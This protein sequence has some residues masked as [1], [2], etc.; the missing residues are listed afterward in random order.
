MKTQNTITRLSRLMITGIAAVAMAGC[1]TSNLPEGEILYTGIKSI[2]YKDTLSVE[3][4]DVMT[5]RRNKVGYDYFGYL[6]D[7]KTEVEAALACA[8]NGAILGSSYM[9]TPLQLRLW[10]YNALA[11]STSKVGRWLRDN[12]G[13]EPVLVSAVN[14]E[15]RSLVAENVLRSYGFFDAQVDYAVIRKD[16]AKTGKIDYRVKTRRLSVVD[17]LKYV[18]FTPAVDSLIQGSASVSL[19]HSGYPFS[20]A[21]LDAERSRLSSMLRNN[22][23]YYFRPAYATYVADTVSTPGKVEVHLQPLDGIPAEAQRKWYLGKMRVEMRR[24]VGEQLTDSMIHPRLSVYYGGGKM[25]IRPRAI[26]RDIK[27]RPGTL[28]SQ[29]NLSESSS[30]INSLGL[31]SVSTFTFSPRDTTALCDT[32]DMT[33][34]CVLDKPYDASIEA[35]YSLKS[36]D[37]TGPGLVLGL[38]KRNA[39]RGGEKLSLNLKGS[40]EWQTG[41]TMGQSSSK[42]NSYEYGA[43]VSI[44]YPRIETPFGLFKHHRFYAPPSTLFSVSADMLNRAKYYKMLTLTGAVTYKFQTTANSRHEFSPLLIDF[45]HISSITEDFFSILYANVSLLSSMT[46]KFIPKIKYS[47]TYTSP[48]SYRNP[49]QWDLSLTEAGNLL[50][51]GYVAAGKSFSQTDKDLFGSPFAQFVKLTTSLRKTWQAGY[52][53]QLVARVAGGVIVTYGNSDYTPFSESFYV[54]GANSIRAFTVR[55]IGPGNY[56]S[57]DTEYALIDRTGDFKLESNLEY[58]F[59]IF[60]GLNGAVFLDAGNVWTLHNDQEG[61]KGKLRMKGFFDQIATGTGFGFRYDLDFLVL[62]FDVGIALHAPYDTGKNGYYNIP[63][64]RDGMA[65]HFAI[66]YPF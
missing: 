40:Y 10:T 44:E 57:A 27:L 30:V 11:H 15:M 26:L 17:T 53:S 8:P 41:K 48:K 37:R 20:A 33:L 7:V 16:S 56:Y 49:I 9:R 43:D 50:S 32:L 58:R 3:G 45:T 66:G 61:G 18:G 29:S 6:D 13:H 4:R 65:Y 63:S 51:L 52:K 31:F 39:F 36:N 34:N 24:T 14:P 25:P 21:T 22:G 54:G 5:D 23:F 38:T 59:N 19:I 64:F 55:S 46:D 42:I 2:T 12:F 28:F 62:R 35:K 1:S 60:G 47:Y